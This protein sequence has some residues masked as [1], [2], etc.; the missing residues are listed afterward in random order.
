MDVDKKLCTST[1][2]NVQSNPEGELRIGWLS[3]GGAVVMVYGT[4]HMTLLLV[5]SRLR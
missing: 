2:Y 4:V 1:R 5:W 3:G